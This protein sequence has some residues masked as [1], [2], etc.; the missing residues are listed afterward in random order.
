VSPLLSS[1]PPSEELRT[2]TASPPQEALIKKVRRTEPRAN[3]F[4]IMCASVL[5]ETALNK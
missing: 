4:E 2:P 5:A 3:R 1:Q